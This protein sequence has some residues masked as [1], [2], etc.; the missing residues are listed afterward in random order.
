MPEE[1]FF[2]V[3]GEAGGERIAVSAAEADADVALADAARAWR[4]LGERVDAPVTP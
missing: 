1:V 2:E 3:V 4:S